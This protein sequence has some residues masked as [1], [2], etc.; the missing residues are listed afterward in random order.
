M[1]VPFVDLKLQYKSIKNEIDAALQKVITNSQFIQGAEVA[2]FEK[3]FAKYLSSS[4]C[5]SLNSGTDALILGVR[6]L[7][8]PIK[9]EILIPVNTYFATALAAVE[10]DLKP[11]FV[12]IDAS[13]FGMNLD[14]LKR[15]INSKTSAIIIVHLYGQPDKIDEIKEIIKKKG[16][17]IHIIEDAAQ[18]H[19][20]LYKKKKVGTFGTFGAFSFY[21]SKNLGAFG[22]G[23][24]IV[25]D[26]SKLVK[27]LKMLREY[28]QKKKNVHEIAGVNSRLDTLQA[29]I[30]RAKLKHLDR[31]NRQRQKIAAL[32]T[33]L[34][35]I[36]I[37]LIK[38]PSEFPERKSIYHLYVGRIQKRD[39][40][41]NFLKKKGITCQI[42]YPTPLHLQ[43]AF[44]FLGYKKGD[45]P[46]VEKVFSE[47]LSLPM[48]PELEKES[49]EYVVSQIESFYDK[50]Y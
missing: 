29:A 25:S 49:I 5:V 21:P 50:N 17:K 14:D 10:N 30:L 46:Q 12:D 4:S 36:K 37:P 27:K 3:E 32:Y 22:D 1:L 7:N 11:V 42:H 34:L 6:A 45:F 26:N 41:L 48:Y 38:T 43:R 44:N 13:D 33:R 20:A 15:K 31:W 35:N 16:K 47:I 2:L 8:L 18:A 40:L 23:G 24:A 19:G 28:G 39:K 9:S